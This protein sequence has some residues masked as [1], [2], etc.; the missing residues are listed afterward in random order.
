MNRREFLISS[1]AALFW[2][3]CRSTSVLSDASLL[4]VGV[5]SDIHLTTEESCRP[6]ADAFCKMKASRVDAVLIAGDLSDYGTVTGLKLLKKTWDAVF[7]GTSVVPL[8]CTGNHDLDG[9]YYDDM[10][11]DRRVNGQDGSDPIQK[12][13]IKSVW[14]EVFGEEWAPIRCRTV[15]GYAFVSAEYG[16]DRLLPKW[17]E[18]HGAALRSDK[19]FFY[20]QHLPMRGSTYDSSGWADC[21]VVRRTLKDYPNCLAF[22][23]HTHFP[24]YNERSIWQDDYTAISVP[25]L[26]Y[27]SLPLVE[28]GDSLR[29][30][31]ATNVMQMIPYRRD[32]RGGLGYLMNVYADRISV[33][34]RDF[35]LGGCETAPA[36]EIP[37]PLLGERRFDYETRTKSAAVPSFPA[38]AKLEVST[39]NTENRQGRWV[40]AYDCRFPSA[41]LPDATRVFDYELRIVTKDGAVA[42]RKLFHSPAF[43]EPADREPKM[44]RFFL[45][46]TQVPRGVD[47]FIEVAARNSFRVSGPS[48]RS[49]RLF[50]L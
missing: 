46:A 35:A 20:F 30:G 39:A 17:L 19:P 44:Q 40:I 18:E 37:L 50:S 5:L 8:F 43:A 47:Y 49:R 38:N 13:N 45:D 28:N 21:G 34:R 27:S 31:S 11:A 36:W 15:K 29:D 33:E 12:N 9:Q 3:G 23:G 14:Q 22:T 4:R 2:A 1:T 26:S 41:T 7:A 24:Y 16:Q 32:L 42:V 25:S 48:I 10:V 6:L